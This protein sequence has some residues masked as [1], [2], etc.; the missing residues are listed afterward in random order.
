MYKCI[1]TINNDDDDDDDDNNDDN[2]LVSGRQGEPD[3]SEAP[4]RI[5]HK[6]SWGEVC[7]AKRLECYRSMTWT[8]SRIFNHHT[9]EGGMR[10]PVGGRHLPTPSHTLETSVKTYRGSHLPIPGLNC[11]ILY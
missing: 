6:W 10:V 7:V 5:R 4:F 8:Q 2:N 1:N 9:E 3:R 11:Y